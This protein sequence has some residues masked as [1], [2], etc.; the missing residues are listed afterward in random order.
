[1]RLASVVAGGERWAAVVEEDRAFVTEVPGLDAALAAAID[2]ESARGEWRPLADVRLDAPLRPS[3]VFCAGQN[4]RDH[5]AEKAPVEVDEPEFFLK[6]GQT[7]AAPDDPALIERDVTE[8]LDY[9]TELGIVIGRRGRR[10]NPSDALGHVY[11][12]VVVND[13]TAR[14]RQVKVSADGHT[15][16]SLGTSKN[17][18]GSTR[19]APWVTTADEVGDP[20]NLALT[21]RVSGELRQS[22]TTENMLFDVTELI[23]FVSRFLTLRPGAVLA[24]G[25][26]GGTGWGQDPELGGTG[27]TPPGCKPGRYLEVGDKVQSEVE[28]V[29]RLTFEV[30][31]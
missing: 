19:I 11:G 29:G 22:N 7:I 21:T 10:V 30:V 18:D 2:L 13:L 5:L 23:A 27:V 17:F 24:T 14:D 16:L 31:E 4:Y 9:E 25:T 1:M 12:Y 20:G 15:T 6:A 8:K 26:P 28:R 3:V